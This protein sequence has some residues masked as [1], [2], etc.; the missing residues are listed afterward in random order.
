MHCAVIVS[1]NVKM[2]KCLL[3]QKNIFNEIECNIKVSSC[4][5]AAV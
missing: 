1:I 3:C 2:C 4:F 5:N